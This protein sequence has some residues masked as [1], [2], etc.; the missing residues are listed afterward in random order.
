MKFKISVTAAMVKA[1]A[2]RRI[3]ARYP[4]GKQNTIIMRGGAERD[5][6]QAAI[7]AILAASHRIESLKP[8]PPDFAADYHWN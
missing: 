7:E 5:D 1:E 3:I 2:E 4:L 8:L 6:M